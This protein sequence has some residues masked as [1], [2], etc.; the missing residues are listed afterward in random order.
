MDPMGIDFVI[1]PSNFTSLLKWWK[2][3]CHPSR[4]ASMLW[5]VSENS[6]RSWNQAFSHRH[7]LGLMADPP[8]ITW[9]CCDDV[10]GNLEDLRNTCFFQFEMFW[11]LT[12]HVHLIYI[13]IQQIASSKNLS[14]YCSFGNFIHLK[15]L[16]LIFQLRCLAR[17]SGAMCLL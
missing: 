2:T 9:G 3:R 12:I 7:M 6:K 1:Q 10:L 13:L 15:R 16:Q 5:N 11:R 4:I 8:K 14:C 17:C